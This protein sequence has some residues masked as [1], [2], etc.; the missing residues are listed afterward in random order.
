[1]AYG[2]KDYAFPSV[3]HLCEL[4]GMSRRSVQKYLLEL[5]DLKF[6]NIIEVQ[7]AKTNEYD[8]NIYMLSNTIPFI[9]KEQY[10]NLP[11]R[12]KKQHD[13]FVEMIKKR[14]IMKEVIEY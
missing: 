11:A 8:S 4:T 12:L 10:D 3:S 7:D 13:K 9:S 14:K 2:E 1:M 6:V 5:A